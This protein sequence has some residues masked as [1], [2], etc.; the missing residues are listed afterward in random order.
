MG[1]ERGGAKVIGGGGGGGGIFNLFDWKRKSR[2]KLFSNSPGRCLKEFLDRLNKSVFPPI[3]VFL[4]ILCLICY[5]DGAKHVKRSEEALPSGRLHLVSN[6]LVTS[7][8]EAISF[9]L[10]WCRQGVFMYVCVYVVFTV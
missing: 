1:P 8:L 7:L 4:H 6:V 9:M 5:S 2:K 3:Y 10:C